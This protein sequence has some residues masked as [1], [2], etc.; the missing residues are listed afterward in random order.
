MN[1]LKVTVSPKSRANTT[2]DRILVSALR[3]FSRLG[4]H[5]ASMRDIS[6][7]SKVQLSALHYHFGSKE[8][9]FAAVVATLFERLAADRLVHLDALRE[10]NRSITVEEIVVAFVTPLL[11]LAGSPDG[12]TY[13]RLQ[14]RMFDDPK[15]AVSL[16]KSLVLPATVPFIDA[17]EQALPGVPRNVIIR[18]YRAM[19]WGVTNAPLDPLYELL[20]GEAALPTDEAVARMRDELVSY[21]AAGLRALSRFAPPAS[22]SRGRP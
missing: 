6:K 10:S 20:T 14:L 19:V 17:L 12:T 15:L 2:R 18:G 8:D 1:E 13:L 21:H 22:R 11:A 9:L 5:G 4:L 3:H 7:T 16:G